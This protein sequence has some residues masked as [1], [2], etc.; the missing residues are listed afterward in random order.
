MEV[1]LSVL[2]PGFQGKNLPGFQGKN[3]YGTLWY[4][5]S[6]QEWRDPKQQEQKS[7]GQLLFDPFLLN[8]YSKYLQSALQFT[9]TILHTHR[10]IHIWLAWGW[11][12]SNWN[13]YQGLQSP[14][15]LQ[16]P[17][18]AY[19]SLHCPYINYWPRAIE[20]N[21]HGCELQG[22]ICEGKRKQAKIKE[23]K[24]VSFSQGTQSLLYISSFQSLE[25]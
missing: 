21:L 6:P 1:V 17:T 4:S 20:G 18:F 19:E 25:S 11:N 3:H 13:I 22:T 2:L 14:R 15:Y 16:S 7:C 5:Q 9:I 24:V 10:K 23:K 8:N 12:T